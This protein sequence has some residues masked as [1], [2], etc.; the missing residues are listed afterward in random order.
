MT[1]FMVLNTIYFPSTVVT[2][3]K[4]ETAFTEKLR[5]NI[6]NG[7]K[8]NQSLSHAPNTTAYSEMLTYRL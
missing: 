7:I 5:E 6:K 1:V 8:T 3:A 2:T 4:D